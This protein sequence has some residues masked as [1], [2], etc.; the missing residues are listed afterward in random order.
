MNIES[1][2]RRG[3]TADYTSEYGVKTRRLFPWPGKVNTKR[4]MTETG[5]MYVLLGAGQSVATHC[6]DEEE[7]FIVLKGCAVLTIDADKTL[8]FE[9]DVAYIPRHSQH[10]ICNNSSNEIFQMLDVYWDEQSNLSKPKN[11]S[12]L[13]HAPRIR[14]P[15]KKLC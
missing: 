2:I 6:H 4:Q 11:I 14:I 3:A 15:A 12:K 8:I 10:S 7:T 9:G 1:L 5:C 13:L